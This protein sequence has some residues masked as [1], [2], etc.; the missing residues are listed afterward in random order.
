M[1]SSSGELPDQSTLT[2]LLNLPPLLQPISP[3]LAAL[4]LA[5]VRLSLSI[6]TSASKKYNSRSNISN[7]NLNEWCHLCGGFRSYTNKSQGELSTSTS[8]SILNDDK[9]RKPIKKS[10]IVQKKNSICDL[11]GEKYER[12]KPVKDWA[13]IRDYPPARKS[14][15]SNLKLQEESISQHITNQQKPDNTVIEGQASTT[16]VTQKDIGELDDAETSKPDPSTA[17]VEVPSLAMEIDQTPS[18]IP[19]MTPQA[20]QQPKLL[21]RPPLSHIPKSS[22]NL[23]TY[24][25]PPPVVPKSNISNSSAGNSSKKKK[26]SGLAKL[27]AENKERELASKGNGGMWGLG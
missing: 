11:C 7:V 21:S 10:R 18:T 20:Q 4:H 17:S 19:A 8:T 6:P 23:P 22:P 12:P 26:K 25:Q 16:T 27:L 13:F 5:R 14:R 24:P 1:A 2:H 3:S 15:R 9:A